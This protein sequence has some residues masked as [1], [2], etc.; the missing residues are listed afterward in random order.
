[1]MRPKS[2]KGY[3]LIELLVVIAIVAILA[4]IGL[5]QY[6]RAVETNRALSATSTIRQVAFANQSYKID[7]GVY[8]VGRLTDA[9]NAACCPGVPGCPAAAGAACNLVACG[10][11]PK[12][13]FDDSYWAYYA[14]NI[15]IAT[16]GDGG[17]PAI[18][19]G[20]RKRCSWD[21]G[22][23]RCIDE[24]AWPFRCWNYSVDTSNV[25]VPAPNPK[26]PAP[27]PD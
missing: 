26:S 13:N 17:I 18:S 4:A 9:C 21:G 1:M 23:P 11:M 14:E 6:Q 24:S 25:L 10:Y 27:M 12:Q 16:C 7:H 2:A 22:D 15:V 19:C 5:P 20:R 8:A 3:T